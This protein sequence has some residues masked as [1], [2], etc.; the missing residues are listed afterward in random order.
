MMDVTDVIALLRARCA[1]A[2]SQAKWARENGLSQTYVNEVLRGSRQPGA[3]LLKA[4]GMKAVVDY[5]EI[6]GI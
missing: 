4:L 6:N 1:Q 5:R 2:G 3:K